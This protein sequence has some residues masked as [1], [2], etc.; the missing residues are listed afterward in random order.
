[1]TEINLISDLRIAL[2]YVCAFAARG[3]ILVVG[4]FTFL[5]I[6]HAAE[7]LGLGIGDGYR[8]GGMVFGMIQFSAL[9]WAL[10]MGYILDKVDRTTGVIIAFVLSAIGYTAFGLVEDPFSNAI[11]LPA[12]VLGMGES[13]TIIAGNALIGQSAPPAIRG[14]VLGLFALCGAAGILLATSVGGR[15]FDFW[16]PGAP[17]M[18]MGVINSA[19]L[20]FAISV[21]LRT[22]KK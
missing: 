11:I 8:R 10:V 5:W 22:G 3:D 1:M 9:I 12:I 13:S 21:R 15:L 7:D 17:F 2:A 20:V 16:T 4:T 18:M 6:Q 19:V 14:A